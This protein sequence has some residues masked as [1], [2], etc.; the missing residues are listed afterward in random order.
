MS[1]SYQAIYNDELAEHFAR[2]NDLLRRGDV[3]AMLQ[4]LAE[5]HADLAIY[6]EG[7]NA[8]QREAMEAAF[9]HAAA[10]S[11][12]CPRRPHRDCLAASLRPTPPPDTGIER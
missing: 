11:P 5:N 9:T 8:R 10:L 2:E 6:G 7:A 4:R 12:S 3:I 1:D